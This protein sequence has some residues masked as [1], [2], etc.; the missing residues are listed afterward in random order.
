MIKFKSQLLSILNLLLSNIFFAFAE[1][2]LKRKINQKVK[3]IKNFYYKKQD[4]KKHIQNK[5]L[6]NIINYSYENIKFYK[7]FYD[8][9][10]VQ[11]NKLQ[12]DIKYF[13]D[14]PL[15]DKK[16][17][18]ENY[19][20]FFS[21]KIKKTYS[22]CSS[23]TTGDSVRFFYDTNA[24]DYSSAVTI[25]CRDQNISKYD[26]QIHFSSLVETQAGLS[27]QDLFKSIIFN[28]EN[29]IYQDLSDDV[30]LEIYQKIRYIKPTLI[31]SHPSVMFILACYV[32]N[33]FSKE[34]STNMFRMF[35]SS[36]EILENYMVKKITNVFNC[37]ILN[38]Y[39][40]SEF[41]IVAYQLSSDQNYL[42]VINRCFKA[43]SFLKNTS[44]K[45]GE[46][47]ISGLENFYMPLIKY[48]SGDL[49]NVYSKGSQTFIKDIHGRVHDF[50]YIDQKKYSTHFLMDILDH[51]VLNIRNFQ[52]LVKFNSVLLNLVIENDD[53]FLQTKNNCQK[54]LPKGLK[55]DFIND[56][57]LKL[58]GNR[59]K[60]NHIVNI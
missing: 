20:D 29:I 13:E 50:F 58:S 5:K 4:E 51:K 55:Y 33:N 57:E 45:I 27:K 56:S 53:Y 28:R 11:I 7:K 16:I 54:Y 17:L 36:G 21:S 18:R 40:L 59:S 41:G 31:H 48:K 47:V 24:A 23:G 46:I 30:L 8:Q 1:I 19:Y 37:K 26:K 12:N 38:R 25:F 9:N 14:F 6:L 60:F 43:E 34:E 15:I 10:N 35:E 3:I 42:E 52:I 44:D 32:E 2:F 49:G 22:N 39:G